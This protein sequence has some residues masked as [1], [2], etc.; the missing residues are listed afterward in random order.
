VRRAR[1]SSGNRRSLPPWL[2]RSPDLGDTGQALRDWRDAIVADL[3]CEDSISAQERV[4]IEAASTTYL[5]LPSVDRF[6]LEQ[7]SIVNKS[8]RQL[9]P[10]ALERQRL[11]DALVRYLET[12]GLRRGVTEAPD[13]GRY[14]AAK[15]SPEKTGVPRVAELE[16][17]RRGPAGAGSSQADRGCVIPETRPVTVVDEG[18]ALSGTL[19][20]DWNQESGLRNSSVRGRAEL[21]NGHP[22]ETDQLAERAG[23]QG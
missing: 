5:L 10:I 20:R 8:R 16:P 18:V 17:A 3:G 19:H 13:L 11:A 1:Q 9:F 7:E 4:V 21:L 23:S 2:I 12:L 15:V 6:L 14:L 22:G